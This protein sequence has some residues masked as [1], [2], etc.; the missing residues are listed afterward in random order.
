MFERFTLIAGPCVL[1]DDALNTTVARALAR[2]SAELDLPVVFKSS[3]DKANRARPDAL[4]GPGLEEGLRRLA[5]VREE[6][7]LPV[8]TDVHL[9][10]QCAPAA[11]TVDVLQIPAVLCRQTDLL[12]A[13]GATG[14]AA[15]RSGRGWLCRT[16]P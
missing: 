14:R 7:G 5:R 4:R 16:T 13:A 11:E 1:E 12:E 9:P 2:L 3:F 15:H 8:L 6:T 10:E